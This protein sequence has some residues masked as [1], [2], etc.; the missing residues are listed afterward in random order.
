MI[1]PGKSGH[2]NLNLPDDA[3]ASF[4]EIALCVNAGLERK[5]TRTAIARALFKIITEQVGND[6]DEWVPHIRRKL[7]GQKTV[8]LRVERFAPEEFSALKQV[9]HERELSPETQ[10]ALDEWDAMTPEQQAERQ[11]IIAEQATA[12][13]SHYRR[14]TRKR[15]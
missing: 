3:I 2:L 13:R 6:I 12:R 9:L 5:Y 15:S 8:N 14:S 10:A 7:L 1:Y 11:K 4:D